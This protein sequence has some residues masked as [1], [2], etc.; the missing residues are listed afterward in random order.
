MTHHGP[1][2]Y[3]TLIL[4]SVS[5]GM[6]WA[7]VIE[8]MKLFIPSKQQMIHDGQRRFAQL[9]PTCWR[10]P[11][12]S[13]FLR[14]RCHRRLGDSWSTASSGHRGRLPTSMA[15]KYRNLGFP[16]AHILSRPIGHVS[17]VLLSERHCEHLL[18]FGSHICHPEG[19]LGLRGGQ[20][21]A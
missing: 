21:H 1:R 7:P 17:R 16:P 4:T 10:S 11:W 5:L 14:P 9:S 20:S 2:F 8:R 13:V 18:P 3:Y 15:P 6:L 19:E 12:S